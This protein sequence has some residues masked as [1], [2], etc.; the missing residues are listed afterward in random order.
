[1]KFIHLSDL[2]LGK[3]VNEFSMIE[4]QKDI[5]KKIEKII[6]D[7]NPDGILIA[8]D[9]Y[10]KS[11]PSEEAVVLLDEFLSHLAMQKRQVYIISGNHDSAVKLSFA[12]KLI[13]GSGIHIAPAYNG[14]EKPFILQDENG[15]VY[16]YLLPFVKPLHVRHVFEGEEIEDYTQALS[17]AI[18]HM[19]ID[20]SQRNVLVAHQYVAG[21][22]QCDSEE[23]PI[24]GLDGVEA[25]VFYDFDYVAL[26]HLHGPQKVGKDC[27]RYSGTPLKYSFSE[28]DH[29]KSVT[30]VSLLEKG[31]VE[32]KQVPLIPLHDMR[33]VKGTYEQLVDKKNYEGTNTE[34]YIH[35]ILQEEQDIL[36]AASKLRLVYP[37]LMH[38]TYDNK[39]TRE[40]SSIQE[41]EKMEEY[42]PLE[43]FQRFYEMRNDTAMSEEQIAFSKELMKKIWEEN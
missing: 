5:L 16:I 42:S 31:N 11:V 33:E 35:A 30:V 40:G 36:N 24:G 43:L 20:T 2:H 6:D 34:D 1:M 32:I 26:G 7:E 12:S 23:K 13:D 17:C 18:S 22:S 14:G 41:I 19:N 4:D 29:K 28:K 21:A 15:P 37:N 10:D 25:S 39:R 38:I 3:R 8:G 27:I 9:I